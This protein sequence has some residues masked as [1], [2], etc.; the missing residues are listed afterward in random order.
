[1]TA[2]SRP[3]AS[4]RHAA[5]IAH[6]MRPADRDWL[7]YALPPEG[8]RLLQDLLAEL[9]AL[10]IPPD[11]T[12]LDE[13]NR[14]APMSVPSEVV[15]AAFDG[16]GS[17]QVGLLAQV[18]QE[19]PPLLTARLLSLREWPWRGALLG[20]MHDVF[21]AQVRRIPSAVSGPSLEAALHEA[22]RQRLSASAAVRS[23]SRKWRLG[24]RTT[25]LLRLLRVVA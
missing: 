14:D 6:A 17:A 22:L 3:V 7:L 11:A 25:S 2:T 12:L 19:E 1:M 23:Q 20:A 10:G 8:G 9:D 15:W 5:L 13:L 4:A 21:V 18:L 24:P 16:L